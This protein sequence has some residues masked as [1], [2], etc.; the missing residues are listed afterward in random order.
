MI[1]EI[2]GKEFIESRIGC[3]I[4]RTHKM[5]IEQYYL[6]YIGNKGKC[7]TCGKNTK[8]QGIRGYAKFCS[9][10]CVG[11]NPD[12]QEQKKATTRLH[13]GV[14]WPTQS[15]EVQHTKI[16][17]LQSKYSCSNAFNINYIHNKAMI[18]SHT[19]EANLKRRINESKTKSVLMKDNNYKNK[20]IEKTKCNNRIK[21][22]TDWTSNLVTTRNKISNTVK[23]ESC[24]NKTKQTC[25]LK[26][27]VTHHTQSRHYIE[28]AKKRYIYNNIS[29]DSSWELALY[30][31]AIDH[32]IPII[33][34]PCILKYYDNNNILHSY[35]PDFLFNNELVEIKGNQFFNKNGDLINIYSKK[36]DTDKLKC[37]NEN[38]VK[39][40]KYEDIKMYI[41][42]CENKYNNSK[43]WYALFR[44]T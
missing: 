3:H 35:T 13:F 27:G 6:T 4:T 40:L 23:S 26:Y 19:D 25:L 29:F 21:Y 33:R 24:Q 32:N 16:N 2:C 9:N 34:T 14:D 12:I 11:L 31:Y 8:F 15:D 10:Q 43:P 38:N 20:I 5:E 44:K 30:I 36:I 41:K 18:N 28:N 39:L 22:G 7:L 37:M 42:Y 17:T 1:C